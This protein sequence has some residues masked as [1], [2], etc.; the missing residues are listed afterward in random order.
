LLNTATEKHRGNPKV[1][2]GPKIFRIDSDTLALI[3]F[4]TVLKKTLRFENFPFQKFN[5]AKIFNLCAQSQN[6]THK[7]R[8]TLFKKPAS[9]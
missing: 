7:K 3:L 9:F 5:A 4:A 8:R 6:P 2:A 1:V